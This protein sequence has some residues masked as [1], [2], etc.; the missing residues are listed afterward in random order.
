MH[1]LHETLR[2][3]TSIV[4]GDTAPSTQ[5]IDSLPKAI[6][7]YEFS[8]SH[9]KVRTSH[10][11]PFRSW[12]RESEYAR[13]RAKLSRRRCLRTNPPSN[14]A[15]IRWRSAGTASTAKSRTRGKNQWR[16]NFTSNYSASATISCAMPTARCSDGRAW[17]PCWTT[18]REAIVEFEILLFF[19]L[20]HGGY[21]AYDMEMGESH[22]VAIRIPQATSSSQGCGERQS[23]NR[24][25]LEDSPTAPE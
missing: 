3:K 2:V 19:N 20:I 21:D 17:F 14:W 15:W 5:F 16:R 8:I 24:A 6:L 9:F 10:F 18:R 23:R 12:N 22:S 13:Q 7:P 25:L 4:E 1:E 11:R